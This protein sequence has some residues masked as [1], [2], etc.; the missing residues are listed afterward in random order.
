MFIVADLVSL[1]LI[2][3]VSIG[4]YSCFIE[5][6][7]AIHFIFVNVCSAI[8][9]ELLSNGRVGSPPCLGCEHGGQKFGS[10]PSHMGC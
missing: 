4:N 3:L 5:L 7:V 6:S 1:S 2:V 9:W 10:L 8:S